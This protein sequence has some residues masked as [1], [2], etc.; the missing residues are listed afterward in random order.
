[1]AGAVI[2]NIMCNFEWTQKE[3][4][5]KI[6]AFKLHSYDLV[7]K[8]S[9]TEYYLLQYELCIQCL[10]IPKDQLLLTA[11]LNDFKINCGRNP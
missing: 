9:E 8:R 6:L 4:A 7:L 10:Q 5:Q 2:H 3:Q 11:V 1:M